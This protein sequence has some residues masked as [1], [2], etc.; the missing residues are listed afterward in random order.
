MTS[1][2]PEGSNS[3]RHYANKFEAQYLVTAADAILRQSIIS[4]HCC[5][6]ATRSA[7][8][9]TSCFCVGRISMNHNKQLT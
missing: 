6:E 1:C 8:P 2:D 7:I 3:W 5:S 4:S 9:A